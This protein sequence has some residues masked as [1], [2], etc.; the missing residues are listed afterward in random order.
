MGNEKGETNGHN[1]D[2]DVINLL[3]ATD[4]KIKYNFLSHF[5]GVFFLKIIRPQKRANAPFPMLLCREKFQ[6]L[7]L[8]LIRT[9]RCYAREYGRMIFFLYYLRMF[10]IQISIAF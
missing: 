3:N 10:V 2:I 9:L 1:D 7:L 6:N 4:L 8:A 5:L